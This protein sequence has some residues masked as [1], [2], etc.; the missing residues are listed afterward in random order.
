M[1]LL[2]DYYSVEDFLF[3]T[4]LSSLIAASSYLDKNFF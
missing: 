3:P 1:L 2:Y 4:L